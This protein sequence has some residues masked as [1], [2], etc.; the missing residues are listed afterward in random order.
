MVIERSLEPHFRTLSASNGVEALQHVVSDVEGAIRL[1]LTDIIM[2]CMDGAELGELL[3]R[4]RPGLP[5]VYLSGYAPP[6]TLSAAARQTHFLAKP[7]QP[8]TLLD[9]VLTVLGETLHPVQ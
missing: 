3:S 5:V 1:V 8:Q 7:F 9:F 2:P 6:E 4:L